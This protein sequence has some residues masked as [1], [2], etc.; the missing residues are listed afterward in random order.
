M[1]VGI[2]WYRRE[3]WPRWKDISV[4]RADM[5]D[6]YDEWVKKAE[7]AIRNFTKNAVEVHKVDISLD[8]FLG[9][10]TNENVTITG[11]ARSDFA[12]LKLGKQEMR[13][14]ASSDTPYPSQDELKQTM[15]KAKGMD[16][17]EI[18]EPYLRR[19]MA[20]ICPIFRQS[21]IGFEQIGSS[22]LLQVADVYFLLTAAHVT[23]ERRKTPLFIPAKKGFVNL[24]GLFLESPLPASG[25]RKD[26]KRDV[27]VLKLSPDL[28]ARIH[29]DLLFL[30]HHDCDLADATTA[31]D[32]Y[33]VIGYPAKKSETKGNAVV[34]DQFSLSG[35]GVMDKRFEQLGLDPLRHV[36]VQHRMNRAIHYSN[37]LRWR[38]PHPQGMSGGGIFAWDKALPE[39][40]ALR[41]PKLVGIL[42]EY[43]QH[44]NVFIG[45]RLS[46]HLMAIHTNDPT[47]PIA[48]VRS[49]K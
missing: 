7:E 22:V 47:L 9:W 11:Y 24:F 40:S 42:T 30:Q 34:T 45:T 38:P 28:I 33:T 31:N 25:S 10:A 4:D 27:A 43:H 21:N 49:T 12:N 29:D 15:R 8:E 48:P 46:A 44:K 19:P 23:D 26:D 18:W 13:R 2:P 17:S 39:V 37:M 1:K 35:D 32:V 41:Q 3:E 14:L 5:C 16:L 20:A 36:I 6:C